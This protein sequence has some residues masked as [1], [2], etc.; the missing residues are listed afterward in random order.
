MYGLR[1]KA[2]VEGEVVKVYANKVTIASIFHVTR[3]TVYRRV[4]EIEKEIGRR[5]NR[6]AILNDL[7]SIEVY[8]DYEKYHKR[9]KDRNLRKTVPPFDMAEAREYLMEEGLLHIE[10][11]MIST[12]C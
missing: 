2:F 11:K 5:Y 1:R 9:L 10:C 4:L 8:A 7:V 12:A 6:Y 3:Q